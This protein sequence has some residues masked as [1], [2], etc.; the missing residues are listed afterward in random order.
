MKIH[1][2]EIEE[3]I[4]KLMISDNSMKDIK[5]LNPNRYKTILPG[6][7]VILELLK[8]TGLNTINISVN[9]IREGYLMSH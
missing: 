4:E 3:I 5:A 8:K 1:I 6:S 2:T 9:G 7:I